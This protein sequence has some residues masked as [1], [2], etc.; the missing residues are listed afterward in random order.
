MEYL[1]V[2]LG[3]PSGSPYLG[4]CHGITFYRKAPKR[5]T[6]SYLARIALC[7]VRR[8]LRFCFDSMPGVRKYGTH[9]CTISS[10]LMTTTSQM[11]TSETLGA[12]PWK[13]SRIKQEPQS[14]HRDCCAS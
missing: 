7:E 9:F 11:R 2:A 8:L 12:R 3:L 13:L 5:E 14:R 10:D 1:G 4:D 6:K